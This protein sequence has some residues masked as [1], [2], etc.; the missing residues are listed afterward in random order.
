MLRVLCALAHKR[1]I[2][3]TGFK[4]TKNRN[5]KTMT[6]AWKSEEEDFEED[7]RGDEY[8]ENGL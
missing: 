1:I 8:E 2:P 4:L 3:T 5:R 6:G 7:E